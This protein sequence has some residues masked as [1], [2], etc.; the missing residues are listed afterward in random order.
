MALSRPLHIGGGFLVL[1]G[2]A[3]RAPADVLLPLQLG[4]AAGGSAS[5]PGQRR[6]GAVTLMVPIIWAGAA[7]SRCA[8]KASRTARRASATISE[9]SAAAMTQGSFVAPLFFV[10][11]D[12]RDVS[13]PPPGTA[14]GFRSSSSSDD[15]SSSSAPVPVPSRSA[16]M[17]PECA[18][19]AYEALGCSTG[20]RG[21]K[22]LKKLLG[23]Q[24]FNN[25]RD[26]FRDVQALDSAMAL[27]VAS[28][29]VLYAEARASLSRAWARLL[30]AVSKRQS[31]PQDE[32][33][34]H[35]ALLLGQFVAGLPEVGAREAFTFVLVDWATSDDRPPPSLSAAAA[36]T[37]T[38]TSA[39]TSARASPE[40]K[41]RHA[42][43]VLHLLSRLQQEHDGVTVQA[44]IEAV[45]SV[46][47]SVPELLPLCTN[48][49]RTFLGQCPAFF[50][51]PDIW[52]HLA[53]AHA[54]LRLV[55]LEYLAATGGSG[56]HD[57]F[58]DD[59]KNTAAICAEVAAFAVS[60]SANIPPQM[61]QAMRASVVKV[62]RQLDDFAQMSP[63]LVEPWKILA[64]AHGFGAHLG[65]AA[66][67]IL[68][69]LLKDM[70][71]CP[72]LYAES[73]FVAVAAAMPEN[74]VRC[75]SLARALLRRWSVIAPH[76]LAS[77][78][79]SLP[80]RLQLLPKSFHA[81]LAAA[82]TAHAVM[83]QRI[84]RDDMFQLIDV[85]ADSRVAVP[86]WLILGAVGTWLPWI[87]ARRL[88]VAS[89]MLD[90]DPPRLLSLWQR[91][92]RIA[93]QAGRNS[94][95]WESLR[96]GMQEVRQWEILAALQDVLMAGPSEV[97]EEAPVEVGLDLIPRGKAAQAQVEQL[98]D[99]RGAR[100]HG[101]LLEE[102]VQRRLW[103]AL[104]RE[105]ISFE[106]A[107]AVA[108]E[109]TTIACERGG[110]LWIALTLCVASQ[111]V[112]VKDIKRLRKYS[113]SPEFRQAVG[114]E[115][116][117]WQSLELR[118]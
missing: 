46:S 48:A 110:K 73:D 7:G 77:V 89:Q 107:V 23:K 41:R 27:G 78:L 29:S 90:P 118:F 12:R 16:C 38:S 80:P 100:V 56:G 62:L 117:G 4:V 116:G 72:E 75:A 55:F 102:R 14:R 35:A 36:A 97:V 44:V 19:V 108:D 52:Y 6:A 96:Q 10:P 64:L 69:T 113:P 13:P 65:N 22:S 91:W 8:A 95:L 93:M 74:S 85:W 47:K 1:D 103:Q 45:A 2:R 94:G 39:P 59:A 71:R 40:T 37:R 9:V 26:E 98:A 60:E 111:L 25:L 17:P 21:T 5:R 114:Q 28:F 20:G 30:P 51:T 76:V 34:R 101:G 104:R 66:P 87:D 70:E 106:A 32:H 79:V 112:S 24:V 54:Q 67:W 88:A 82:C 68:E 42:R 61:C 84:K 86:D 18:A 109:K 58:G 115:V 99:L 31:V 63:L 11:G 81:A 57:L 3:D 53:D 43:R 49:F 92:L 15:S 105:G 33:L 83:F 50:V